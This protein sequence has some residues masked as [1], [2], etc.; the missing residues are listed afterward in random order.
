MKKFGFTLAEVLITLS[1]IGVVAALT[2]PSLNSAIQK[3][4][5]GPTL[6][7]FVN[8]MEN[9]NDR[10]M[11]KKDADTIT[12]ITNNSGTYLEDIRSYIKGSIDSVTMNNLTN[13]I[14]TY[15]GNDEQIGIQSNNE[16][17]FQMESG[18][19]MSVHFE[20]NIDTENVTTPFKG[21]AATITY[22]INGF[23]N[24][25]NR[26]GKD[27]FL[28][29]LDNNGTV[30]PFGGK[31]DLSVYPVAGVTEPLWKSSPDCGT[32]EDSDAGMYC[33]GSVADNGWNVVYKY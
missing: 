27:I 1:I 13:K 20:T 33:A 6:R 31:S 17:I 32:G 9:A 19:A 7:K 28:F 24:L 21:F 3:N 30:I 2:L 29:K 8:T 15:G 12:E 4:K 14:K 10:L 5:V 22:D 26:L 25:P 11:A 16:P 23:E 18:D